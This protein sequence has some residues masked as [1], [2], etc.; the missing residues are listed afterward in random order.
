M[1]LLQLIGSVLFLKTVSLSKKKPRLAGRGFSVSARRYERRR[2][3]LLE[4]NARRR[5]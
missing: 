5:S 1:V 2:K 4:K 3:W